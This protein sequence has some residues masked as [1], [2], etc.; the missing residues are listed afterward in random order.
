M[1][2]PWLLAFVAISCTDAV[3]TISG[4]APTWL[5]VSTSSDA[6]VTRAESHAFASQISPQAE[7]RNAIGGFDFPFL[8][9][10]SGAG[11]TRTRTRGGAPTGACSDVQWSKFMQ[12]FF[13]SRRLVLSKQQK[14]EDV[15]WREK[16]SSKPCKTKNV[17]WFMA[18]DDPNNAYTY[19]K[20]TCHR[21]MG[22]KDN[23]A[24]SIAVKRISSNEEVLHTLRQYRDDA[25][26]HL[27]FAGH[28]GGEGL[29]WSLHNH[30][31]VDDLATRK[32]LEVVNRKMVAAGSI[33]VD[34]CFGGTLHAEECL[35]HYVSRIVGK[36]ITVTSSIHEFS[37]VEVGVD[38]AAGSDWKAKISHGTRVFEHKETDMHP[39]PALGAWIRTY[40]R[41]PTG[42]SSRTVVG[43]VKDVTGPGVFKEGH[44]SVLLGPK[45]TRQD[46]IPWSWVTRIVPLKDKFF[47]RPKFGAAPH[48]VVTLLSDVS[49]EGKSVKWKVGMDSS[50]HKVTTMKAASLWPVGQQ[51]EILG[52]LYPHIGDQ[53]KF[54]TEDGHHAKG[55]VTVETKQGAKVQLAN[56]KEVIEVKATNLYSVTR[57]EKKADAG[58]QTDTRQTTRWK[59]QRG[60]NG[61]Y[62]C[63]M[64]AHSCITSPH[65]PYQYGRGSYCKITIRPNYHVRLL[66]ESFEVEAEDDLTINSHGYTDDDPPPDGTEARGEIVWQSGGGSA[67]GWKIC[68]DTGHAS[69]TP[70]AQTRPAA[71]KPSGS[72]V[73]NASSSSEH[74]QRPPHSGGRHPQQH[75]PHEPRAHP[76]VP[77]IAPSPQH[78][79][80]G[81]DDDD[82][83]EG[84]GSPS[85]DES[86]PALDPQTKPNQ[87]PHYDPPQNTPSSAPG[88]SQEAAGASKDG[89]S[90]HQVQQLLALWVLCS[91][92]LMYL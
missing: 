23:F 66:V 10:P 74:E 77:H 76:P 91:S 78:I 82:D 6:N 41:T 72:T 9:P 43:V 57:P 47:V 92:L 51:P 18:K 32:V 85:S 89:T 64:D 8:H 60:K 21:L 38:H 17:L 27:V 5:N 14:S 71:P 62:Q 40:Y 31:G 81:S 26:Q 20:R 34:S 39:T 67:K 56:S 84:E 13:G 28:G 55:K 86:D 16:S 65:Y 70:E 3:R 61:R 29:K 25:I 63:K 87:G 46:K 58:T 22:W 19:D 15:F 37:S 4:E 75:N 53:V 83:G 69:A 30:F 80:E 24:C 42:Q 49:H 1:L 79:K 52:R 36:N 68:P 7:G 90:S 44:V 35:G 54:L 73:M 59:L 12:T 2:L 45:A 48:V 50:G 88:Q 33:F 11:R